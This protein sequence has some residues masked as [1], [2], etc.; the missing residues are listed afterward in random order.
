M[1][2]SSRG[3]SSAAVSYARISSG[4]THSQVQNLY[5]RLLK[6]IPDAEEIADDDDVRVTVESL[7]RVVENDT[8]LSEARKDSLLSR[9]AHEHPDAAAPPVPERVRH[10]VTHLTP[11]AHMAA[12]VIHEQLMR[13]ARDSG[14]TYP[15]VR[16]MYLEELDNPSGN[17]PQ[18]AKVAYWGQRGAPNDTATVAA[19]ESLE[20]TRQSAL[21]ACPT[22]STVTP[23]P[24][25]DDQIAA[26]GYDPV[27][28]Y[29]EVEFHSHPGRRYSYRVPRRI[30]RGFMDSPTKGH[31]YATHILG[32]PAFTFSNEQAWRGASVSYRCPTCGRFAPRDHGC[33]CPPRGSE[34]EKEWA[35]A[36][37][38]SAIS[39]AQQPPVPTVLPQGGFDYTDEGI[40]VTLP[41]EW[42]L[43]EA[44][45]DDADSVVLL[46]VDDG[47][48]RI[49]GSARMHAGEVQAVEVHCACPQ[50]ETCIHTFTTTKALRAATMETGS[51]GSTTRGDIAVI[52]G[53]PQETWET[54]PAAFAAIQ[55][56]PSAPLYLPYD[57]TAGIAAPGTGRKFGVEIEFDLPE[58]MAPDEQR[59]A[60]QA[61]GYSLYRMKLTPTRRQLDAHKVKQER[62]YSHTHEHGWVFT[63]DPSCAGEISSPVM[64]DSEQ[65]WENLER[66]LAT[67]R[68]YGGYASVNTGTHVHVS[69]G[70]FGLRGDTRQ[71]TLD[72]LNGS[73]GEWLRLASNPARGT[74]RG[75]AF[76]E[77]GTVAAQLNLD[78]N[79]RDTWVNFHHVTGTPDDHVEFRLWDATLDPAVTQQQIALSVAATNLACSTDAIPESTVVSHHTGPDSDVGVRRLLDALWW[80]NRDKQQSARLWSVTQWQQM[81]QV[82]PKAG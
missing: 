76:C 40:T 80:R 58:N 49:S 60:L 21:D 23:Q 70:D 62:N 50:P 42:M 47:V 68:R 57:A 17:D 27:S 75:V 72:L 53:V 52:T 55:Q 28:R 10:A 3:L 34:Q 31:F 5:H 33:N 2:C 51:E 15:Q 39:G 32:N 69:A 44:L 81:P 16:A 1:T 73:A 4:L 26:V 35:L 56:T 13:T 82:Y 18:G 45:D 22:R 66:V 6:D 14:M 48:N 11:R 59:H 77:P 71:R 79:E 67:V 63:T 30:V 25:T 7:A 54:S 41:R 65:T 43:Q 12:T 8:T 61:I 74:H 46:T 24:V 36:Y 29:L 38:H 19:L 37:A 78:P 64:S 20:H 9:L